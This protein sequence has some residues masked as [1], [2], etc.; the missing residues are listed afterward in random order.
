[1]CDHSDPINS[2]SG[3][4][5]LR[6]NR[7]GH[8]RIGWGRL[9]GPSRMNASHDLDPVTRRRCE[10]RRR[11]AI[12]AERIPVFGEPLKVFYGRSKER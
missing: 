10:S 9:P 11:T 4:G 1:M 12:R 3:I 2:G 8:L 5:V 6:A 7:A